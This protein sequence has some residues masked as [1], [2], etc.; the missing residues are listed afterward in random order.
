M[1]NNIYNFLFV[2]SFLS[3]YSCKENHSYVKKFPTTLEV[4]PT[5]IPINEII[6][7]ESI[8]KLENYIVLRNADS[9]ATYFF[10]VYS[11]PEFKFLYSFCP[12]G[13][14][15]E[16]FL[17]PT[18]IKSTLDNRFSFRDHAT[19]QY[20]T[21]QL[22]DTSA[23]QIDTY[24]FKP[25]N[26]R[27][28]WEINYIKDNQYLLKRNNSKWST[29]ELWDF[30]AQ[31]RMDSLPN[32]FDLAKKM[33]KSYYTEFDDIWISSC[34][35]KMAFAYFFIDFIEAGTINNKKMNI[36]ISI[37]TKETPEFYVF[38]DGTLGGKYKYNVDYNIVYYESLYCTEHNIYA[39]Y[40][41]IPWGDLEKYHSS[42]IE[43]YDW[44]GKPIK[45]LKLKQSICSFIVD[46]KQRLIYGFN[47]AINEDA[48]LCYKY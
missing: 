22:S 44:N 37:G 34:G 1:V 8:Y 47:P 4:S 19:D 21:F 41:G 15:P 5:L 10:Y 9:N 26:N 40:A 11:Y 13:N 29:R 24:Y 36:N 3:F 33:G 30:S 35:E 43:I 31:K 23:V 20:T 12:R 32:T 27:F 14:G 28:F 42:T 39:L 6:K 46:E 38:K 16:E 25:D 7:I 18:V 2:L 17:M 48:I 45:L